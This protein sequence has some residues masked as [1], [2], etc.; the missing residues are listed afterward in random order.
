MTR[1]G[2]GVAAISFVLFA[3]LGLSWAFATPP[4]SAPDEP[5]HT[6]YAAAVVRLQVDAPNEDV[7]ANDIGLVGQRT[8]VQLDRA[9]EDLHRIPVCFAFKPDVD[10]GCADPLVAS[11]PVGAVS[12]NAGTY[13]PA[14]YA[15]VGWPSWVLDPIGALR[16]ARVLTVLLSAALLASAVAV[17]WPVRGPG[18]RLLGLGVAVT[19]MVGYLTGT[20]NPN[21]VEIAAAV[22]AWSAGV[23]LVHD[24]RTD[25]GGLR[26]GL[27]VFVPS[28]VVLALSRPFG[29]VWAV[30]IVAATAIMVGPDVL[31]VLRR[32]APELRPAAVVVGIAITATVGWLL[33]RDTLGTFTGIPQ[34]DA[35]AGSV[36]RASVRMLPDRLEQMV[37][38][39]GWASV[40]LPTMVV[41]AWLLAGGLVAAIGAVLARA[42]ERI[43]IGVLGLA[44]VALPVLADIQA[45]PDIGYAWQG[46]YALPV[47]VGLPIVGGVVIDR[48]LAS[49]DAVVPPWVVGGGMLALLMGHGIA[50]V[51]A[52]DRYE[53]GAFVRLGGGVTGASGWEPPVPDL[54]LLTVVAVVGVTAAGTLVRTL[55]D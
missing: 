42:G 41:M 25:D 9:Y 44:V 55:S 3:V 39:F 12:T 27:R 49:R 40:F 43:V 23:R 24:A 29:P 37:G 35:T 10:A 46:R 26:P 15:V 21:A 2:G 31:P 54:L 13:P 45:V 19:P 53:V 50:L 51:S 11:Q 28:L 33:W 36:L 5:A 16:A 30:G 17:L 8:I 22:A 20:V 38:V 14:Y 4:T 48:W 47:A 6:I 34:P 52:L 1:P 7:P 32:R 18:V